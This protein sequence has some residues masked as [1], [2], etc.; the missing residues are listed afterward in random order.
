MRAQPR[1]LIDRV[2]VQLLW[3]D[4]F[5]QRPL[6]GPIGQVLDH[7]EAVAGRVEEHAGNAHADAIEVAVHVHER[8]FRRGVILAR[9]LALHRIRR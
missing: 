7:Q 9:L 4:A 6:E 3:I 1:Q 8:Q 5:L 2:G